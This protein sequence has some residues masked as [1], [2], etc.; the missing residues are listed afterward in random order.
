[1][2]RNCMTDRCMYSIHG[3]SY[4]VEIK[5]RSTQLDNG[6]MVV[7]FSV[8]KK[9]IGAFL[10]A[11]DHSIMLWSADDP[12]YINDM[13]KHSRRWIMMPISPSAEGMAI[14]ILNISQKIIKDINFTNGERHINVYSVVVHETD[15][16]YA[17][18]SFKDNDD[19]LL[20]DNQIM[21]GTLFS[22]DIQ[23]DFASKGFNWAELW[24]KI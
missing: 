19:E 4:V 9:A 20:S 16:G 10:D 15:T 23:K 8:I 21:G 13:K 6:H 3:H 12:V 2:V 22:S 17:E 5:L 1:M 7:D 24:E 11:F 14:F 18:A